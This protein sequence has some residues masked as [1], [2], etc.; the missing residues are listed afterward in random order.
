MLMITL[1]DGE[2]RVRVALLALVVV[3]QVF[4]VPLCSSMNETTQQLITYTA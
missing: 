1:Y 2:M 4:A 3:V